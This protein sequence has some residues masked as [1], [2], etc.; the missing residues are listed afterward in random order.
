MKKL[1]DVQWDKVFPR[2]NFHWPYAI[3]NLHALALV[4]VYIKAFGGL[5]LSSELFVRF[6]Q[7]ECTRVKAN[8][9]FIDISA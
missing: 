3:A 6:Y 5:N 7:L 1:P 9:G 2:Q 8:F 4:T